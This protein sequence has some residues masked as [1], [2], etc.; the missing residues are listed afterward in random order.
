MATLYVTEQGARIEK[1][2]RRFLVTKDDQVLLAVPA[3][4]VSHVVLVGNVGVTTPAL[5]SLLQEGVGLSLVSRTGELRGQLT[6]ATGKNIA[7][8]HR[9][10]ERA[11]DPAFCLALSTALVG[12]K[13]RNY[14]ALARRM[15]RGRPEIDAGPIARI[16][17][18]IRRLPAAG[19]LA[20]VR[21]LEGEGSRAYFAMLRQ[22]LR[23]G[24]GF[25]KRTR[26][27]PKD[28]VNALLSLGYTL[29]T[30]N[31]VTACEVV[32]LDPYDGF[33]HADKYGRP[34]LALDLVEE[35]RGVIVDS[36]VMNIVNRG[37]LDAGDFEP[38]PGGGVYLKPGA[39][40]EFFRQYSARLNAGVV[41]PLAGRQLSYQKCFEVQA[42]LLR[43][44][45]EGQTESYTSFLTK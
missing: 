22:A 40:K 2:Y 25:E 24:L 28:P 43:D 44:V 32:G 3:V 14:R 45:I 39:M 12:G 38:G 13:L 29:L 17:E 31:L 4:R 19:D 10:Y 42:R 36:V 33:F 23:P 20:L 6:P 35:F 16:G 26:R 30:H 37:I 11:G 8:R 15:A 1:E 34:A 41:H 9:Q 21:G 18:C 5:V 7:L 27:P